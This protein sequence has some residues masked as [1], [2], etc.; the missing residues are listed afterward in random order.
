MRLPNL[1]ISELHDIDCFHI[2]MFDACLRIFMSITAR[3]EMQFHVD[4]RQCN[5]SLI[6]FSHKSPSLTP[7]RKLTEKGELIL[8]DV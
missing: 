8:R 3:V 4:N 7:N 2:H 1:Y 6:D 5:F